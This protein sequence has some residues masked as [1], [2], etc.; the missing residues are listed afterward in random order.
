MTNDSIEARIIELMGQHKEQLAR[1][2]ATFEHV[3]GR[4]IDDAITHAD[5][6]STEECQPQMHQ[7]ETQLGN[8]AQEATDEEEAAKNSG[9]TPE[10]SPAVDTIPPQPPIDNEHVAPGAEQFSPDVIEGAAA[11]PVNDTHPLAALSAA[12]D[13]IEA[14]KD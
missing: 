13:H 7:A 4:T 12:E 10:Q 2:V 5:A 9:G 1:G 6:G 8:I 14:A 3:T 11:A